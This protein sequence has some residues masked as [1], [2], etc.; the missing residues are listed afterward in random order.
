MM[1]AQCNDD[2]MSRLALRREGFEHYHSGR[3]A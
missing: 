2:S 1:I 3:F